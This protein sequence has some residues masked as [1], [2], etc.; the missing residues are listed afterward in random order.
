M[1][2][3][4]YSLA[5]LVLAL[6]LST[7]SDT[8]WFLDLF[9]HFV[10]QYFVVSLVLAIYF[11]FK[12]QSRK[13]YITLG[14]LLYAGILLASVVDRRAPMVKI[15][16]ESERIR[17]FNFNTGGKV[18]VLKNWLPMHAANYDIVVLLETGTA[19]EGL[20]EQLKEHFPHQ[21]VHIE[22]SP[23]GLAVLSRWEISESSEFSTEGGS[24]PQ[25]EIKVKRPIGD[26]FLLYALHAPPPFAP[27]LAEAHEAILGELS[28]RIHQKTVPAIVV[29]DSN[30]TPTSHRFAKLVKH[31]GLRDTAGISPWA[32]TWPTALVN[33]VPFLGI[34]IDHCLVSNSFSIV[35]RE[36][37][38]DLGSDHMPVKCVVQVER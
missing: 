35:E 37:L 7:F 2:L 14:C 12:K 21:V 24:F 13:V 34:R 3:A 16:K 26:E 38:T 19:F 29:G 27:Q 5:A 6:G 25:Y 15:P 10:F 22:N 17:I 4:N 9:S 23:F 32:N 31:T 36:R 1:T 20:L 18:E 30:T 8:Q 33:Y 11:R 28:E